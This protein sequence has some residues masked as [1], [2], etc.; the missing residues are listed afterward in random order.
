MDKK[1]VLNVKEIRN[2]IFLEQNPSDNAIFLRICFSITCTLNIFFHQHILI[3]PMSDRQK[4]PFF[5]NVQY[6]GLRIRQQR[7]LLTLFIMMGKVRSFL[8]KAWNVSKVIWFLTKKSR[9]CLFAN[10]KTSQNFY[11]K[12]FYVSLM[13]YCHSF[14]A[15]Q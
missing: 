7:I 15:L 13:L 14:K 10:L 8:H 5:R 9:R 2:A 12:W 4:H 11:F 6:E 3:L 1:I